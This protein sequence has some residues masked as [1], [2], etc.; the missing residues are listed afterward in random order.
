MAKKKSSAVW[1]RDHI[2]DTY[3]KLAQKNG[4]RSRAAFKLIGID[5]Q[6]RLIRCGISVIDLGSAPGAWSQVLQKRMTPPR[7]DQIIGSIVALDR[8]PMDPIQ[9][10]SFIQGDFYEQSVRDSVI[11]A[12]S[13]PKVD[14]ILSDM[15]PNLSG[16]SASDSA[17]MAD[18]VE[19]A[20]EFSTDYLKTEGTLLVKCFH[21]SGYS[22]L[23]ELFKKKFRKVWVRKP[24]ASRSRSSELYLLG[25]SLRS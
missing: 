3:V 8:L 7:S 1:A 18:L 13:S 21:G 9:G 23:V 6:D 4:Y 16:I 25:N 12:V 5:D 10:V 22:Q 15:A 20:V 2:E 11:A 14:L 19:S 24:P 17:R